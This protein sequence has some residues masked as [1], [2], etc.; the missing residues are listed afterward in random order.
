MTSPVTRGLLSPECEHCILKQLAT[1]LCEHLRT[2]TKEDIVQDNS[3]LVAPIICFTH[4]AIDNILLERIKTFAIVN[5]TIVL[6]WRLLTCDTISSNFDIS[7][8]SDESASNYIGLPVRIQ[9]NINIAVRV[10]HG[11]LG[12][13]AGIT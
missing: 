8:L 2:L 9:K 6:R 1:P 7:D 13:L 12:V 11:T 4:E 10:V 5:K 3:W